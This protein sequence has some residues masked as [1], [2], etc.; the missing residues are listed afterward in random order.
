M[1]QEKLLVIEESEKQ[2][3]GKKGKKVQRID[4]RNDKDD[5]GRLI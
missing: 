2:A 4:G 1:F 5:C 3:D